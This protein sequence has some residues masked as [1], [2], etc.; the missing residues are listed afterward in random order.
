[1]ANPE[2]LNFELKNSISEEC[3]AFMNP[4]DV[5]SPCTN[6]CI[7]IRR[8]GAKKNLTQPRLMQ[9]ELTKFDNTLKDMYAHLM[10]TL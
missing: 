10:K 3:S 4:T 7:D 8:S 9:K 2:V 6:N 1:M 5:F